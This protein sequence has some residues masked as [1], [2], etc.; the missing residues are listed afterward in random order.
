MGLAAA[1]KR[2]RHGRGYGVHSPYAFRM[3]C[4]VLRLPRGYAYHAYAPIATRRAA[5]RAPLPLGEVWLIYRLMVEFGARRVYI[6]ASGPARDLIAAITA[7]AGATTAPRPEA[8]D[9]LVVLDPGHTC[10]PLPAYYAYG[11][12]ASLPA[13]LPSGHIYANP[14]RAVAAPR[15]GIPYQRIDIRF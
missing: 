7:I 2:W 6:A 9:M 15:P 1:Y 13:A 3:V 10:P 11:G 8:A 14:R 4:D 12:L 5:L